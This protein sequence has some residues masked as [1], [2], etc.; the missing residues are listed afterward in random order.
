[1]KCPECNKELNSGSVKFCPFCGCKIDNNNRP[2]SSKHS[3]NRAP[4]ER[5][6]VSRSQNHRSSVNRQSGGRQTSNRT[7]AGRPPVYKQP[8]NGTPVK[9]PPQN[10]PSS[11]QH[12]NNPTK[13]V[14]VGILIALLFVALGVGGYFAASSL[15]SDNGAK[16]TEQ[17]SR[18]ED[19]NKDTTTDKE[20]DPDSSNDAVKES[21]EKSDKDSVSYTASSDADD[22]KKE[23]ESNKKK[24]NKKT[25]VKE[26]VSDAVAF[27]PE[28]NESDSEESNG[29]GNAAGYVPEE[30]DENVYLCYIASDRL[31][32][33]SDYQAAL[34]EHPEIFP[35]N[36][37]LAQMIE[38]ELFARHGYI[39]NAQELNDY[40]LQYEW[41]QNVRNSSVCSNN[42]EVIM[43]G[44]SS[45][46]KSNIKFLDRYIPD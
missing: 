21:D 14:V 41:Y 33:D 15:L 11:N 38:N 19:R 45:I 26:K 5:P 9:K 46:E 32:T 24:E 34:R 27:V 7:S 30:S 25:R 28:E 35:G 3:V 44:M 18:D 39:F 40:F 31:L 17:K 36:R 23:S 43:K 37:T 42:Q 6:P 20:H 29:S 1:M 16:S 12:K 4:E 8:A 2:A 22:T 13:K 10:P